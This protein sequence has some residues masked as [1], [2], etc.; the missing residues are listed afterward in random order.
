MSDVRQ[1][2]SRLEE[3]GGTLVLDGDRVRYR[4]PSGNPQVSGLLDELRRHREEV[5]EVLR[6]RENGLAPCGSPDCAGCY[7]ISPGVRLHPP[8]VSVAWLEWLAKWDGT[9]RK[10]L[11]A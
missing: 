11:S 7:E 2:V 6:E 5:A 10:G 4:I 3:S 9:N 1:I 8:K